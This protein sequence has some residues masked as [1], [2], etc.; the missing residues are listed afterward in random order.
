MPGII[1][2]DPDLLSQVKLR[3][4]LSNFDQEGDIAGILEA[5]L[6]FTVHRLVAQLSTIL[7]GNAIR[8]SET[9]G[10]KVSD[11]IVVAP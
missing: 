8:Q 1:A 7:R 11:A 9:I 2:F 5:S 10:L 4:L 6:E 3:L